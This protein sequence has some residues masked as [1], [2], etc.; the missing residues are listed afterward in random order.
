LPSSFSVGD[1]GALTLADI[2]LEVTIL[3][4]K[5]GEGSEKQ[6]FSGSSLHLYILVYNTSALASVFPSNS[7]D[8]TTMSFSL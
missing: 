3:G 4:A 7:V 6:Q 1:L 2:E 8:L 5:R